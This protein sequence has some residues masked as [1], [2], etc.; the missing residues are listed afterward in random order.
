MLN[1][2]C[3]AGRLTRDPEL[4]R[5]PSGTA[6]TSFS[7][8]CDRDFKSADG[9]KETD[10]VDVVAWRQTAEFVSQY[11][12][13]GRMVSVEGRLQIRTWKDKDGKSRKAAEVVASNVYA[14]DHKPPVNVYPDSPAE[15]GFVDL[16]E[17]DD[18]L[19]F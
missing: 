9:Q 5:T 18:G 3:I 12:G 8:A 14:M 11:I 6:V 13:K 19:P 2:I 7:I 17:P 16:D 15:A 1:K 10:F 4:K